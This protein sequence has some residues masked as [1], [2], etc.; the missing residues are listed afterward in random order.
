[1]AILALAAALRADPASGRGNRAWLIVAF[2]LTAGVVLTHHVTSYALIATLFAICLMPLPW[3]RQRTPRPWTVAIAAIAMTVGWL[4]L[5]AR[6][7]VGYLA[8]V[9][10][11]AI[12]ET[13]RT[14]QGEAAVR[15]LFGSSGHVAQGPGWERLVALASVAVV[16]VAVAFGARIV[17]RRYRDRPTALLF[18]IA[19]VGYVVSLGLRL[20]PAAWEVAVRASEF[21]FIGA[22]FTLA[23]FTLSVLERYKGLVARSGL[24]LAALVLVM[25]GV[26]STTPSSTRLAQPYR[27]AVKGATLEPQAAVAAQW[28][29]QRFGSGNRVAAQAA[30]GRFFLVDGRQHVFVGSN[31]P[32]AT[33]LST[34]ALYPWQIGDLRRYGIR[35]VVTDARK[36]GADVSDGFYFF[37][38][39]ESHSTLAVAGTKFGQAGAAPIYDSGD[40]VVYDLE[41]AGLKPG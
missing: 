18:V 39:N 33:I 16:A 20:V 34:K 8:P 36:S 15:Q 26:I 23:L 38:G 13:I 21:L 25:G 24:V 6:T 9:V 2:L 29:S 1:M 4:A 28:F 35:F 12:R 11:G 14:V 5:M 19:A 30:D 40:I 27:V 22:S 31:P 37:A 10:L 32:I 41:G 3:L 7:T 17:W